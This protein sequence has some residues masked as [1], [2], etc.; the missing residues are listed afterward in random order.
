MQILLLQGRTHTLGIAAYTKVDTDFLE[1]VPG[2]KPTYFPYNRLNREY[3]CKYITDIKDIDKL[4]GD[5]YN[6]QELIYMCK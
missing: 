6:T 1:L 2:G 5:E 3:Y 4:T